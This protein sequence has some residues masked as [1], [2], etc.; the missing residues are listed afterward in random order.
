[1]NFEEAL[2]ILNI[3]D[4]RERI[5]NSNSHGELFHLWDYI[6][7]AN[8]LKDTENASVFKEDFENIVKWAEENWKRPESIF[9][10]IITA[11][12]GEK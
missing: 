11:L 10:H 8:V 7:I 12:S 2:K 3:E 4:Y 6:T 9:Q 1:M 5:Y